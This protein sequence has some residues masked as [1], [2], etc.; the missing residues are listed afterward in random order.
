[1]ERFVKS[2]LHCRKVL[3]SDSLKNKR[4]KQSGSGAAMATALVTG[5]GNNRQSQT[6]E[7]EPMTSCDVSTMLYKLNYEA[8]RLGASQLVGLICFREGFD[9]WKEMN[10]Y[11]KCG[12]WA[13]ERTDWS[14]HLA[15]Q[16]KA[17]LHWHVSCN[18]SRNVLATLW[19]DKLNETFHSVTYPATAKIVVRQVARAIAES[20]AKVKFYFSCNL[21]RND[22]GR[23]RVCYTVKCFVQ[24]GPPQCRQNIAR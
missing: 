6:M 23:C 12:L 7:F 8:T 3:V 13:E 1:M 16:F 11:L 18:L 10:V 4:T 19:R 24:L 20:S 15:G 14:S 9:E 17:L 22:F 21:S 5:S 2:R